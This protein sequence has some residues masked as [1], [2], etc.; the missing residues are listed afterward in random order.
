MIGKTAF[1]RLV[2]DKKDKLFRIALALVKDEE[3]A[4]DLVQEVLLKMWELKSQLDAAKNI[5]AF[6]V[7][8]LRNKCLSYL[9]IS[10]NRQLSLANRLT[11]NEVETPF[12]KVTYDES[13]KMIQNIINQMPIETQLI[14]CLRNQEKYSYEEISEIT[15]RSTNNLKV[16]MSRTRS[17]IRAQYLKMQNYGLEKN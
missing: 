13:F 11:N 2:E 5:D 15:G 7:K 6:I 9:K 8:S 1:K 12:E 14:L 4:K 17:K 3:V 16:I 10:T